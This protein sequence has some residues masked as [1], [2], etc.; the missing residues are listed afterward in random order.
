MGDK[1]ESD[2]GAKTTKMCTPRS[3][4]TDIAYKFYS[5]FDHSMSNG[6]GV[7]TVV[8]PGGIRTVPVVFYRVSQKIF[9]PLKIRSIK[10]MSGI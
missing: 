4:L 3:K 10:S 8:N 6:L 2:K 7:F 9:P 5:C 1:T